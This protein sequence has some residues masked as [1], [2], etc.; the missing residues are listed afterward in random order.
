[1]GQRTPVV[2]LLGNRLFTYKLSGQLGLDAFCNCR[3]IRTS[4]LLAAMGAS[5]LLAAAAARIAA[6]TTSWADGRSVAAQ[7][8][9]SSSMQRGCGSMLRSIVTQPRAWLDLSMW[10]RWTDARAL[11]NTLSLLY[12]DSKSAIP[13]SSVSCR[14]SPASDPTLS[15]VGTIAGDVRSQKNRST[16]KHFEVEPAMNYDEQDVPLLPGPTEGQQ[17]QPQKRSKLLTV[18]PFILGELT[19]G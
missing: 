9:L 3:S 1:L 19:W 10:N 15:T 12:K 8:A 6:A 14:S 2:P 5:S 11:S 4:K 16:V 13:Q 17:K 7:Y 18:C